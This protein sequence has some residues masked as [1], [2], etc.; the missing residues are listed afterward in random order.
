MNKIFFFIFFSTFLV[1]QDLTYK[2]EKSEI[3]IDEYKESKIILVEKSNTNDIH[4][5][6]S[7]K[8]S[9]SIK[10]GFYIEKYDKSLKKINDFE[11]E[12]SHPV[13][14]K[15]SIVIGAFFKNSKFYIIEIFY[16]LKNKN[17]VCLANIVDE[18]YDISKKEL[19]KL[20]KDLVKG[21]GLETHFYNEYLLD[22]NISNLGLFE[23][24]SNSSIGFFGKVNSKVSDNKSTSNVVFKVNNQKSMFSIAL[25]FKYGSKETTKLFLFD[26][27]L[28]KKI[29]NDFSVDSTT[30]INNNI[31]LHENQE[32]IY[33]TQKIYSKELKN[34][35]SGGEY[36]YQINQVSSTDVKTKKVNI[37]NHYLPSLSFFCLKNKLYGLGFYSDNS[38]FKY[39]G[40][41]F[42]ELDS[43]SLEIKN[44]K[45]SPFTQQFILDKYGEYKYKE[46]KNIVV[47]NVYLQEDG[48]LVNGE[49]QY[50]TSNNNS[51]NSTLYNYDDII[52][53][54][55]NNKGDLISARNINKRQ[56][57]GNHEDS[58]FISYQSCL[59][60]KQN[61]FFI[62][63]NDR[64]KELSNQR[65]EFR[66]TNWLTNSNLFVI[67]M[68]EKGDFLYKQ[69]LSHEE[70]DVPFMVSKAI[71]ID[72]SII[73]LG[74]KGKKKQLLKVTL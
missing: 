40:I 54:R 45:Y 37:E 32:V 41:A 63:A 61:Y 65:I 3:F 26:S 17:Y 8:S 13:S 43:E 24:E 34:K 9:I 52:S 67:S 55:L 27:Y 53:L 12:I 1:A 36:F 19:F 62:N 22:K 11:F 70:N 39:S 60:N 48:L 59:S 16:D 51:L 49:E 18:N 64:M 38:D 30:V 57:A 10:R 5:L 73:F 15:Y 44:S 74:R 25:T 33:L 2:I 35:Q 7:F 28:D 46:L 50:S 68:N 71:V 42:F 23:P 66:G 29:E 47:K 31:E 69:I 58:S 4:V 21:F 72:D 6:R 20:N 14:E 56:S